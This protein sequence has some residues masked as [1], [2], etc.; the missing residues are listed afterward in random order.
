MGQFNVKILT[1][2]PTDSSRS[3]E[4]E[5]L[6]DAGATLS[7]VPRE[8]LEKIGAPRATSL[9]IFTLNGAPSGVPIIFAEPGDGNLLGATALEALGYG[10]GPCNSVLCRKPCW[11]CSAMLCLS[12]FR[13]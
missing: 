6:V 1:A 5:L 2:Q 13:P 4:V 11:P 7:W 12:S 9:A 3:A 10:V 8:I